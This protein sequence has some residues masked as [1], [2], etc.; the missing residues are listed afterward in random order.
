MPID[1]IDELEADMEFLHEKA[2]EIEQR[3]ERV[4]RCLL[5]MARLLAGSDVRYN[6]TVSADTDNN[7]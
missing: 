6:N 3:V 2:F 5:L 7:T 1:S 4:E